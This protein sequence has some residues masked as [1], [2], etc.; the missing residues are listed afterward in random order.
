VDNTDWWAFNSGADVKG[1]GSYTFVSEA[2][3]ISLLPWV[4]SEGGPLLLLDERDLAGWGGVVD[5]IDG[6]RMEESYSPGGK[7]T[8][9][10]RACAVR[11]YLG[12]ISVGVREAL[13]L[14]D[15]PMQ[16]TWM[17]PSGTDGGMLARW[18]YAE[19]E[20][21]LLH[22]LQVMPRGIFHRD[23]PFL[24]ERSPLVL[25]D[26]AFAG[27]NVRK[28]PT[29]YLSIEL[30]PGTYQIETAVYQ[31]DAQTCIVMHRFQPSS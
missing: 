26:S 14:D 16:T 9:Y 18:M 24:V 6:P 17:P 20:A 10:D 31:P 21:E 4:Y 3:N 2:S 1:H 8:D 19:N 13:V 23:F 11:G 30:V 25:F 28:R 27:R 15:M 12:R 29:E 7:R 5:Q 22:W